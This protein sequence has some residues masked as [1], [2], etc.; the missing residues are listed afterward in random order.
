MAH[1]EASGVATEYVQV[2]VPPRAAGRSLLKGT[3]LCAIAAGTS[4]SLRNDLTRRSI[5]NE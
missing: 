3:D 2:T 4:R 5:T 1:Q